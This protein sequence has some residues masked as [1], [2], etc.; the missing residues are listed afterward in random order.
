M[1]AQADQQPTNTGGVWCGPH[2]EIAT[3]QELPTRRPALVMTPSDARGGRRT[4]GAD[5]GTG[6]QPASPDAAPT[7]TYRTGTTTNSYASVVRRGQEQQ[8][9]GLAPVPTTIAGKWS[10]RHKQLLLETLACDWISPSTPVD[11]PAQANMRKVAMEPSKVHANTALRARTQ[12]ETETLLAYLN[13]TL[14]LPHPPNFI[15]ATLPVLQ[16]AIIEQYH[17]SH[18]ETPLS[19]RGPE[20]QAQE[21]YDAQYDPRNAVRGE[22]RYG[23][24]KTN[25]Q[26]ANG[27]REAIALRRYPYVNVCIQLEAGGPSVQGSCTS[28]QWRLP[29]TRGHVGGPGNRHIPPCQHE[30]TVRGQNLRGRGTGTCGA[31]GSFEPAP[32][33]A[34]G[35][36]GTA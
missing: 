1:P 20:G 35:R 11:T 15:K 26:Q 21:E 9:T 18:L 10:P 3:P 5:A 25:D 7:A 23:Q 22:W 12:M 36:R 27:R 19:G 28:P 24:R 4:T 13:E 17:G 32:G 14:E 34:G 16:R 6:A 2:E 33:C 29:G 30:D 31:A 8:A